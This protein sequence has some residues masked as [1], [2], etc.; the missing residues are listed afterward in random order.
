MNRKSNHSRPNVSNPHRV[1][2]RL[3]GAAG[4]AAGGGNGGGEGDADMVGFSFTSRLRWL[5]AGARVEKAFP[6][7]ILT[8]TPAEDSGADDKCGDGG[9]S[10]ESPRDVKE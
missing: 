2:I 3:V 7:G 5:R 10:A 9:E 1:A 6:D 8:R 4:F